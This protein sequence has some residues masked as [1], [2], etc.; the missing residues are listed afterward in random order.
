MSK[1]SSIFL[2]VVIGK[3]LLLVEKLTFFDI[4][5]VCPTGAVPRNNA[6]GK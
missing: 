3:D 6:C 1:D 5:F 2:D 4:N